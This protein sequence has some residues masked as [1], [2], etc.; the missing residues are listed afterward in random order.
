V[1]NTNIC[2]HSTGYFLVLVVNG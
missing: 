1:L 2:L